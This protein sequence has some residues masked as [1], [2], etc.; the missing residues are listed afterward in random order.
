MIKLLEALSMCP[1]N[2]MAVLSTIC[3][4]VVWGL[5]NILPGMNLPFNGASSN[6]DYDIWL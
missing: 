2:S 6:Q 1:V 5:C 3:P 4:P